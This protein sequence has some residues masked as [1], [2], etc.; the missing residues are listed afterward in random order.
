MSGWESARLTA[1]HIVEEF[2][3]GKTLL[4]EWLRRDALR[5]QRQGTA[6]T[7]VWTP[8]GERRVVGYYSI[9]PTLVRRGGLTRSASGGHSTVPAYLLARL[10]LDRSLQGRG[11]GSQLL[12]DAVE[13]VVRATEIGGGRLLVVDAID[14]PAASFYRAHDFEQIQGSHRLYARIAS[15]ARTL[16]VA[17]GAD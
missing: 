9:A 12:L 17:E 7:T 8:A 2:D 1:D 13:T 10:A 14:E 15:L 16:G 6:R 3:S 5:A 11:L 4:D